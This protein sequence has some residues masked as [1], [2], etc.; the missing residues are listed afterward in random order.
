MIVKNRVP[1]LKEF[2]SVYWR[3]VGN[4]FHKI[5]L[6]IE[7]PGL[8]LRDIHILY[9]DLKYKFFLVADP[10]PIQHKKEQTDDYFER[11]DPKHGL[12]FYECMA[13]KCSGIDLDYAIPS[14]DEFYSD[15]R[16]RKIIREFLISLNQAEQQVLDNYK[17]YLIRSE[18]LKRG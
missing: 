10:P 3:T 5:S 1:T 2:N 7:H 4:F 18:I 8:L 14:V 13:S 15:K 9:H 12:R 16:S 17:K 11:I 6:C